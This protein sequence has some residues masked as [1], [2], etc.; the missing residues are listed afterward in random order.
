MRRVEFKGSITTTGRS[1]ALRLDKALFKAHPE[2]R[3][4]AKI[5]AHVIGPGTM[6]VTLDP[7]AQTP[8]E[9]ETVD[10]DPVVSAY[11]AFLERDMTAH[12]ERLRPFTEDA[13]AQLEAL[14]RDVTVS[15]DDVI[16][17]DVTL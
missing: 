14:T 12:P 3:Q 15:D 9:A 2:F 7:D 11:L 10:R 6:L 13:L 17:D 5:R 16:P 1:E 8:E 4:R